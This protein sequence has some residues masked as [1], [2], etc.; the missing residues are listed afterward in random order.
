MRYG[1]SDTA[2]VIGHRDV[3]GDC[4]A[5]LALFIRRNME[6]RRDWVV[7]EPVLAVRG[8]LH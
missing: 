4:L 5:V 7:E 1:P 6:G 3:G 8:L 2:A